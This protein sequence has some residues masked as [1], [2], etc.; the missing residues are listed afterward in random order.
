MVPL[1]PMRTVRV[2]DGGVLRRWGGLAPRRGWPDAPVC[3]VAGAGVS[4][5][6]TGSAGGVGRGGVATG[7]ASHAC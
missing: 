6:L 2:P 5:T 3:T 7:V 4:P 1:A